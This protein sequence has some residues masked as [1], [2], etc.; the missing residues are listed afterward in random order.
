MNAKPKKVINR[1]MAATS[2]VHLIEVMKPKDPEE[3]PAVIRKVQ[4][5]KKRLPGTKL[6]IKLSKQRE[7][8]KATQQRHEP[9]SINMNQVEAAIDD[10]MHDLV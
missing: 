4:P 6:L 10:I 9:Q 7:S 2:V 3:P 8:E 5:K 1:K